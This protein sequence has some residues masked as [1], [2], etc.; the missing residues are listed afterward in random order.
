M[1][2]AGGEADLALEA[3]RAESGGE[4]GM[5]HLERD[6]TV[7]AEVACEPDRGHAPAAKLA[8]ERV[9][10]AQTFA[11]CRYRVRHVDPATICLKRASFRSGSKL[12]S[13]RSQP[14]DK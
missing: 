3:L 9:P 1:L 8:L 4:L 12:G 2:Q 14:G 13:T 6:G 10:I 7:M 5:E 11:Q